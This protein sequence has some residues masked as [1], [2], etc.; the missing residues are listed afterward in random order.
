MS[1]C[2]TCNKEVK[3]EEAMIVDEKSYHKDCLPKVDLM[4]IGKPENFQVQQESLT[5]E[6][7]S[8]K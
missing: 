1:I 3:V 6:K 4:S 5:K 7:P 2:P 8:L